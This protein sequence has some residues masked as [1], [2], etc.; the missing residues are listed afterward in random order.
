M[1]RRQW[2][3]WKTLLDDPGAHPMLVHCAAGAERTGMLCAHAQ[4]YRGERIGRVMRHLV[5]YGQGYWTSKPRYV[6]AQGALAASLAILQQT[7][8]VWPDVA[9]L[10]QLGLPVWA[11]LDDELESIFKRHREG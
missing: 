4:V 9:V 7:G 6:E 5:K 10:A 8:D 11:D 2:S 1:T 3:A